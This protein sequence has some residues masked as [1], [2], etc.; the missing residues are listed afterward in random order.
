MLLDQLAYLRHALHRR[1]IDGEHDVA[2][3]NTGFRGAA[4]SVLDDEAVRDAGLP[5]LSRVQGPQG[6]PQASRRR[7]AVTGVGGLGDVRLLQSPVEAASSFQWEDM[8]G[9]ETM[10]LS[11]VTNRYVYVEPNGG[12]LASADSPGA[13]PD[14][15]E[16]SCFRWAEVSE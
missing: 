13:R 5:A 16:G 8:L 6:Q 10:L 11:L 9:D 12:G 15:K 1:S 2:R 14:R 7:A 4:S 3:L